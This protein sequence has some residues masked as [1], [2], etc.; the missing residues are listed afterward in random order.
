MP[1]KKKPLSKS[2]G[3]RRTRSEASEIQ[4]SLSSSSSTTSDDDDEDDLVS[5]SDSTSSS[6][7]SSSVK[8]T[9]STQ[10]IPS[11]RNTQQQQ[12]PTENDKKKEQ[13]TSTK[14]AEIKIKTNKNTNRCIRVLKLRKTE[15][16]M[17]FVFHRSQI[18]NNNF[19][20]SLNRQNTI[21]N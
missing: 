4:P 5:S 12:I 7:S 11:R 10:K 2:S 17:H 8:N 13:K 18:S 14:D 15:Q 19:L 21:E 9:T 16:L 1:P 6:S 20:I 3:K